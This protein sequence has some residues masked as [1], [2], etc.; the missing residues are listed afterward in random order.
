MTTQVA[1][2]AA[3]RASRP[4]VSADAPILAAKITALGVPDW[5]VRRPRIT[6]LS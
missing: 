1:S 6:S 5:A 4:A 3:A 2:Q